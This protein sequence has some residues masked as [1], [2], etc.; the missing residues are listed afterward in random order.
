[1]PVGRPDSGSGRMPPLKREIFAMVTR[2]CHCR[3]PLWALENPGGA[4]SVPQPGGAAYAGRV[5]IGRRQEAGGDAV[6]K[7]MGRA[8]GRQVAVEPCQVGEG[9][10]KPFFIAL[11]RRLAGGVALLGALGDAPRIQ[12]YTGV[13]GMVGG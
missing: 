4:R 6:G 9:A 7:D 2:L 5:A 3:R 13:A 11:Q 1:M 8:A 10:A 12:L